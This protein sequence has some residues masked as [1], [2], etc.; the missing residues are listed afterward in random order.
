[1]AHAL[2]RIRL[3]GFKTFAHRMEVEIPCALTALVGPNGCGKS[4]LVDA[5]QWAL[6]ET[7]VRALRAVSATEVL[8]NGSASAKPMG[9]AEVSL[10]FSNE[11]RWLPLDADE[12]QITRRLYRSGE[13]ECWINKTPARLRD[14]ADLFAGTGLGRGGYAIVGQGDIEAF[15]NADPDARRLWLEEVAG[16]ALYR[17]RRKSALRDLE[18]AQMHLKR[19]EDVLREL[20]LQREPLREQAERALI[21][22]QLMEQLHQRERQRLLYDWHSLHTQLDRALGERA[23]LHQEIVDTERAITEAETQAERYGEQISTL[24]TEMDTL[25]TL[26]QAQLS[27]EE[28]LIGQQNTLTERERAV[29]E[30]TQVLTDEAN[31]LDKQEAQSLHRIDS[32]QNELAQSQSTFLSLSE[33]LRSA[34][35]E[36][37]RLAEQKQVIEARYQSALQARAVYEQKR[38]RIAVLT[39]EIEQQRQQKE[40]LQQGV[41]QLEHAYETTSDAE[42]RAVVD[43]EQ[44]EQTLQESERTFQNRLDA[45]QKAQRQVE[46]LRARANALEASLLSG[47]GATPSVRALLQAVKKSELPPHYTPIGS[48]IA[49]ESAYLTAI[50]AALGSAVNDIITPTEEDAKRA[51]E[52]LKRNRAGRLTFLPLDLLEPAPVPPCPSFEGIIGRACDLVST[53]PEFQPVVQH[54]LGRILVVDTLDT[55]TAL[56]HSLRQPSQGRGETRWARIV[57]LEGEV[58]QLSGVISGGAY[59]QERQTLLHLKAECDATFQQLQIAEQ[60]LQAE[61]SEL[62][63]ARIRRQQHHIALEQARQALRER[64]QA[65][66]Q[67]E[68]E[69]KLAQREQMQLERELAMRLKELEK[70]HAETQHHPPAEETVQQERHEIEQTYQRTLHTLS[71]IQAQ[72]AQV[73]SQIRECQ[74]RIASEQSQL[75]SIRQRKQTLT[76]RHAQLQKEHAHIRTQRQNLDAEL[77]RTRHQIDS[78][79]Q[80][81]ERMRAERQQ[82]LETSFALTHQLKSYRQ[83]RQALGERERTIDV[84]IARIEVRLNEVKENWQKLLG[85]EP[86]PTPNRT[87]IDM[88]A[89]V[90]RTELE[91]LR[92]ALQEMGE[93]NL[94]ATEEYARL[95]DRY[96][97][98]ERQRDDLEATCAQLKQNLH[99]IDADARTRFLKTYEYVRQAFQE[100][101]QRLFEG[102]HADLI[103]MENSDPLSSG[104]IVEAQPPNK[105]RQRLELLSG[106]ER[107]LTALAVLFALNDVRPSPLYVLDEVDS[108]LDG[109]NVQRFADHLKE[110][111]Q[112]TQ[113][114][115]VTHNPI[116]TAVAQHWLGVTMTGGVSRIVP[117]SPRFEDSEVDGVDTSRAVILRESQA[118][119][120]P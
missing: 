20:D 65:R 37:Q 54:L 59:V 42:K 60:N 105:R 50:S 61:E 28:R 97:T 52:W 67:A 58:V 35:A 77:H 96:Q 116:T 66:M 85:D 95:T 14:I 8:F 12:V 31:T 102:G 32:Y 33:Q 106:G 72:H 69:L 89:P 18:S 29:E 39:E 63:R 118:T 5:I 80:R 21:Y 23:S 19:V 7:T 119:P 40:A 117:Y 10:W 84:Q 26:L 6:G 87:D 41:E 109:R 38:Q 2:T 70:L 16:I 93:V 62:E 45:L 11:T 34:Q 107:A 76:Q 30:L 99:E 17:Q 88:P 47:E 114:L 113:V 3:H 1:M 71:Q 78:L 44:A 103:L 24:E 98:L 90:S 51:I 101:F 104:I 22:R 49:T 43:A 64:T 100:R 25:R 120:Q 48:A 111:A 86:L 82:L 79:Q 92:R 68:N 110:I 46:A 108:A 13:W 83:Q 91:R 9:L 15:L 55:A 57:T 4:N 81:L 115:I 74:Q 27:T 36:V 73:Q 75:E 94:G 56:L 112:T 53:K